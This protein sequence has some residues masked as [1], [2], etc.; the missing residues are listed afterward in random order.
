VRVDTRVV[1]GELGVIDR[2]GGD[3]RA[4]SPADR[5]V[6]RMLGQIE[7]AD[8]SREDP[9]IRHSIRHRLRVLTEDVVLL[10]PA[11]TYNALGCQGVGDL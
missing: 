3:E 10:M 1:R 8:L 7:N 9:E 11:V 4:S 6:L 5:R 2:Y